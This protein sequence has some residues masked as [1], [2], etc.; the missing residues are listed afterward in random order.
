[1]NDRTAT[2]ATRAILSDLPVAT[3]VSRLLDVEDAR[4]RAEKEREDFRKE[5]LALERTVDVV[6]ELLL[7]EIRDATSVTDT[8]TLVNDARVKLKLE[9]ERKEIPF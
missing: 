5:V 6:R 4:S 2:E 8:I 1:M 7:T 3:L 9:R